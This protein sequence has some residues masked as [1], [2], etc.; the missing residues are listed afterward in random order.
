MKT[1]KFSIL[2]ALLAM[3]CCTVLFS[4]DDDSTSGGAPEIENVSLAKNDSLVA[5][6]FADNMYIIRGKNF[7]DTRKIYFNDVDTY[8]NATLVTDN[9]IFV[10]INRTTP[11]ENASDELKVVTPGGTAVYNFR[12]LPPAP[13]ISSF[14]PINAAEGQQF[15]IYG[16]YFLNP[17]VSVGGTTATVVSSTLTE[18]VAI[19]PPG[20]DR[21]YVKVTTD[22][23]SSTWNVSAVGTAIYDDAFYAPYTIESWNNHEYVTSAAD[24]FQ[25]V[26]FIKK[27]IPGWDNIQGNWVWD[28]SASQY[29]GIHFAVKS[30]T[31]GKLEII[32]NGNWSNI[33]TRV[34][35]TTSTWKDVKLTW[36]DLGLT[37][38]P[39]AIQNITFKESSG[40]T[41]V[42]SFDNIGFTID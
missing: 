20:S 3:L 19:M 18:I 31:D 9:I 8:F 5:F 12:V 4:C 21:K 13:A 17:Q 15:T 24:A 1:K 36:A 41:H 25:G 39:A 26:T 33:S 11:Y 7:T 34:F 16:S 40:A 6:G 27:N 22:S 10:T 38:P 37:G 32:F 23:G 35:T 14:T 29:T 2:F 28:E 30:D 42:Y